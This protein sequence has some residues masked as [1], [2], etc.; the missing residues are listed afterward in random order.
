MANILLGEHLKLA[1][2]LSKCKAVKLSIKIGA[3][4][5][6]KWFHACMSAEREIAY[7]IQESFFS[8]YDYHITIP[9][10]RIRIL[11]ELWAGSQSLRLEQNTNK[12]LVIFL[13]LS[14]SLS[15]FLS[16]FASIT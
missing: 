8:I 12:A 15:F 11:R 9:K 10:N 1:S 14:L 6:I 3:I 16:F 13:Y 5:K 4:L 2:I 7:L